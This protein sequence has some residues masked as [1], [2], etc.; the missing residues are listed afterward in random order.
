MKQDKSNLYGWVFHYNPYQDKW[1]CAL[2]DNAADLF[3]NRKSENVYSSS[4]IKTLIDL[5]T[6][7]NMAPRELSKLL[8]TV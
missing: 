7:T 5:I 6:K 3:S 8:E 4:E 1:S 2:R